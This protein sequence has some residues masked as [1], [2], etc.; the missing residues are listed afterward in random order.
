M[1]P[2]LSTMNSEEDP[3]LRWGLSGAILYWAPLLLCIFLCVLLGVVEDRMGQAHEFRDLKVLILIGGLLYFAMIAG[4]QI[5]HQRFQRKL[6]KLK[7]ENGALQKKMKFLKDRESL[8]SNTHH[9]L[10]LRYKKLEQSQG[11]TA[12]AL[13]NMLH[14]LKRDKSNAESAN[15]LKTQ[16]L[17]VVSHE[18]RTP[19]NAILGMNELLEGSTLDDEQKQF[20]AIISKSGHALLEVINDLLDLSKMEA[21]DLPLNLT[22]MLVKDWF[23]GL[24][25]QYQ[26]VVEKKGLFFHFEMGVDASVLVQADPVRLKQ[27]LN[28]FISNAI[29]FTSSGSVSLKMDLIGEDRIRITVK[30]T[31][32]GVPEEKQHLL[33]KSFTQVDGSATRKHG[34]MGMGLAICRHLGH[35]MGGEIG[36]E[37]S[38][39][40][41][42]SFWLELPY[43]TLEQQREKMEKETLPIS[44][45][46][47][48]RNVV[49]W[50]AASE[51]EELELDSGVQLHTGAQ[52]PQPS[53]RDEKEVLIVQL[54][55]THIKGWTLPSGPQGKT[56]DREWWVW[57]PKG[58]KGEAAQ[59]REWGAKGYLTGPLTP[60]RLESVANLQDK[61]DEF[62]TIYDLEG[63]KLPSV[64]V[65]VV[66]DN[67]L[68]LELTSRVLMKFGHRVTVVNHGLR[69]V[70]LLENEPF[71]VVLMDL[72]MPGYNGFE[73]AKAMR[74]I[75]DSEELTIIALSANTSKEAREQA[76]DCGFDAFLAKPFKRHQL[77][78][79]LRDLL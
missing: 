11:D 36:F 1:Y 41:G 65:L 19:M 18:L 76:M 15:L 50:V 25:K 47:F 9:E 30:D 64:Q 35:L 52:W 66:D 16:F 72:E 78:A 48:Q 44:T 46:G 42:S 60:Q 54:Y 68:N 27:M 63:K 58:N 73:T 31:G 38:Q 57:I 4:V 70:E 14:D 20:T 77:D 67:Q 10:D 3:E 13:L 22:P 21:G 32:S 40:V 62:Y 33:F 29:K 28:N 79:L 26:S 8:W 59:A 7:K 39:G 53:H 43:E 12:T 24:E 34:G 45:K 6:F 17:A 5:R 51:R 56:C 71:R 2:T 74:K 37:S 61:S 75:R 55:M 69:A 49:L 23:S